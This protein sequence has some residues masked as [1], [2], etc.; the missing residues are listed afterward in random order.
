MYTQFKEIGFFTVA[1]VLNWVTVDN[2]QEIAGLVVQLILII[3][4]ILKL[5]KKP[6]APADKK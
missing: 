3:V 5:I 2:L 1:S 6:A 4:A